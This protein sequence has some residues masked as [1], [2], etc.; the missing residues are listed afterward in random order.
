MGGGGDVVGA[1]ATAE[2]ARLYDDA[3]P[4]LGGVTWE[5]RPIDPTPGPRS[6]NEIAGAK[7]L[8]T[9]VL[10]AGRNTRVAATGARFA[11][12]KMAEFL[13]MSTLLVD[14]SVG[15][16]KI[17]EGIATAMQELDCDLVVAVDVGG[18]VLAR[19]D[20]SGL[21]SPLCDA[22]MLAAISRLR[23]SEVLAL[24]GIFGVG[25]DG[26]LTPQESLERIS[27][28]GAAGG[29]SGARGLT[30]AVAERLEAAA[31]LIHTEASALPVRAFRGGSGRHMIRDGACAVELTLIAVV[32]FFLEPR[33]AMEAAAPLARAVANTTNMHE[34]NRV[35]NGM[36]VRTELDL[37]TDAAV[38]AVT[39]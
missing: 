27:Q 3:D 4:V 39:R 10:L 23:E 20:E 14:V 35:L 22:L 12:S 17:A 8:A 38:R 18:D 29:I 13:G 21:R 16:R 28:V 1:L 37:E 33:L 36:G 25:C 19:G 34:A 11:E 15:P 7:Q 24:L 32:T 2:F 31:A 26:E 5:R 9:G 30:P 6:A